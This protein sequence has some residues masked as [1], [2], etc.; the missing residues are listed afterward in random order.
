[1]RTT[2]AIDDNVLAAARSAA[3]RRGLTLGRLVEDA[4]RL[5]LSQPVAAPA[6]SIPIF[7][8]GGGPQPGVDLSSNRALA[9]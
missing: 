5:E 9:E 1:M 7:R 8:G 2:L 4:L 6:P 3:R